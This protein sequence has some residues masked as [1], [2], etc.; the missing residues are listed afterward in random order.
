MISDLYKSEI[1]NLSKSCKAKEIK[2]FGASKLASLQSSEK[3]RIP[4][5]GFIDQKPK[6][7]F[8]CSIIKDRIACRS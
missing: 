7:N 2:I 4:V 1:E 6:K 5:E 3:N 8:V